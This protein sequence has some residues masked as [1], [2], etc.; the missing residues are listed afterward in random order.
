MM[1]HS[2]CIPFTY[3]VKVSKMLKLI[4][5]HNHPHDIGCSINYHHNYHVENN[6]RIYYDGVPEIIQVS[7][8][9][10]VE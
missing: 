10:F 8:H 4:S 1:L 6:R 5:N 7:K 2:Q 9:Q 3:I